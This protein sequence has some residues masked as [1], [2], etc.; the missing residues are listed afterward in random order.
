MSIR[1]R[2]L[3]LAACF[4]AMA[5]F[6]TLLGLMTIADYNGMMKSYDHAYENAW[7]G[8]RFNHL[9][10]N[11]V[12]ETRGLYIARDADEMDGFITGLN[13]NLDAL[14]GELTQ[15]KA[16]L[17]AG[18]AD[19]L[20]SVEA[21]TH[22]FI[23][24]RRHI[25][26]LAVHDRVE[27]AHTLSTANRASRIAFQTKVDAIVTRTMADLQAAKARAHQYKTERVID[28]LLVC[29]AGVAVLI[30]ASLW[31]AAHFITRPLKAVTSAIIRTA[32]GDYETPLEDGDGKDEVSTV[33]QALKV[34]KE[35]SIEAERL[36]AAER[37]RERELREI[38]LD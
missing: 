9:I 33:W 10:S 24:T 26:D 37:A 17:N 11:V 36:S 12:M 23:A 30:T 22:A 21:D 15:W 6:V 19:L 14:D 7:R 13:G 27:E 4:T 16:H 25:S 5:L 18:D 34:L 2:I 20:R 29:L 8:E 35:R 3:A 32:K 38:L 31:L 28:F 1:A